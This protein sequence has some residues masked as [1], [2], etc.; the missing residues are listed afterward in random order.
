MGRQIVFAVSQRRLHP[1][2]LT[3]PKTSF[4]TPNCVRGPPGRWEKIALGFWL[5]TQAH[6][7]RILLY[8]ENNFSSSF[9]ARMGTRRLCD[10]SSPGISWRIKKTSESCIKHETFSHRANTDVQR[11][12]LNCSDDKFSEESLHEGCSDLRWVERCKEFKGHKF[13]S[14]FLASLASVQE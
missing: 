12:P 6:L 13:L 11:F 9:S 10:A 3:I 8:H 7:S 1:I 4:Q 14:C 2:K 5:S